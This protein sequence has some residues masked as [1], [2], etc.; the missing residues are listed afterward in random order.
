MALTI[1]EVEHVAELA[2]LTLSEREKG[3][4]AEQLSGILTYVEQLNELSTEGVEPLSHILPVY[5]VFREDTIKPSPPREDM[6]ANAPLPEAG[7][8]KVPKIV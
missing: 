6:L 8:Y 5:N 3:A 2:R 7:Q 1:A 4:F